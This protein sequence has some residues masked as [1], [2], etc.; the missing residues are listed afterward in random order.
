LV[1]A[2]PPMVGK[3]QINEIKSEV[4]LIKQNP[5]PD[6]CPI[7]RAMSQTRPT[8]IAKTLIFNDLISVQE[9]NSER[10][11]L[12]EEKEIPVPGDVDSAELSYVLVH[13]LRIEQAV[14][15]GV[16]PPDE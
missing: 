15:P 11:S 10:E 6:V 16:E 14:S 5:D 4:K 7:S 13:D 9:T 1:V 8:L 3:E 2:V 12:G